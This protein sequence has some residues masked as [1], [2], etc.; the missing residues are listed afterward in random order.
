[1]LRLKCEKTKGR[2]GGQWHRTKEVFREIKQASMQLFNRWTVHKGIKDEVRLIECYWTRTDGR[3]HSKKTP[4]WIAN[5]C[6][7]VWKN[8]RPHAAFSN[9]I[10]PSTPI[11][12]R[13]NVLPTELW[14][15]STNWPASKMMQF[16]IKWQ[17]LKLWITHNPHFKYTFL[18]FIDC[19]NQHSPM[20]E[21]RTLSKTLTKTF[22]NATR[23]LLVIVLEYRK[24][25]RF[26]SFYSQ[27]IISST[28]IC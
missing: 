27:I 14:S 4:V 17:F 8:L 16:C 9:G 20:R 2:S 12:C 25:W 6:R 1:M 18:I 19:N 22:K 23:G 21:L 3:N 15:Q 26:L 5:T 10:C 13:C 11:R 28:Y 7:C 24:A